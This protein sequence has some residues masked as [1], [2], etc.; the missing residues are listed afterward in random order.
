MKYP[1]YLKLAGTSAEITTKAKPK[2]VVVS[3]AHLKDS[4]ARVSINDAEDIDIIHDF[5]GF[6]LH[7]YEHKYPNKGSPEVT[8]KLS[9]AVFRLRKSTEAWIMLFSALEGLR[10]EG[11]LIIGAGMTAYNLRDFRVLGGSGKT[12]PYISGFDEALKDAASAKP[13]DRRAAMSALMRLSDVR[14]VHPTLEYI[15]PIYV[16]AGAAG[17]DVG[18][19]L[20]TTP[21]G[22]LNRAQYRFCM[23]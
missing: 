18:E 21:E 19:C 8:Q 23:L 13:E 9:E 12:V 11:I 17:S 6:P 22:S 10:D 14:Q 5:Y 2:A 20:W 15:L 4:L 16:V 1:A 7:Y 3:S